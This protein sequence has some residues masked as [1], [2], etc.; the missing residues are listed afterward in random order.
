MSDYDDR[1]EFDRPEDEDD[2]YDEWDD[3]GYVNEEDY[4]NS[5]I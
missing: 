2:F 1:R 5:K 3:H 4:W